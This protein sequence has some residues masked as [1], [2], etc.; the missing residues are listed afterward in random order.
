MQNY[1]EELEKQI[2]EIESYEQSGYFR[3]KNMI[4]TFETSQHPISSNIIKAKIEE[5]LI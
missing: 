4:M 2:Q 5:Y 3:G 1:K